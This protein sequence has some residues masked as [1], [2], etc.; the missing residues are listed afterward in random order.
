VAYRIRNLGLIRSDVV[1]C[2]FI[3]CTGLK[4]ARICD[5]LSSE[6]SMPVL[7]SNQVLARRIVEMVGARG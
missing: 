1:D 6:L 7:T 3:S 5:A 4:T 2:I